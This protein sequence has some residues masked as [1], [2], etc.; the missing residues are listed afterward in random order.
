[1]GPVSPVETRPFL[2]NIEALGQLNLSGGCSWFEKQRASDREMHRDGF[3]CGNKEDVVL[4]SWFRLSNFHHRD[5]RKQILRRAAPGR[6]A[7]HGDDTESNSEGG[8]EFRGHT[9][10]SP[11]SIGL[12]HAA[13]S[14]HQEQILQIQLRGCNEI[15]AQMAERRNRSFV[16]SNN[17]WYQRAGKHISSIASGSRCL[18]NTYIV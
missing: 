9:F 3:A 1:M 11:G 12:S 4:V 6:A 16:L 15:V 13:D 2:I 8:Y 5:A 17:F 14:M 10:S 7:G 18:E